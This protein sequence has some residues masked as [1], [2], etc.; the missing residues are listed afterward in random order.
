MPG[1]IDSL[2]FVHQAIL[3]EADDLEAQVN[4]A[5]EPAEIGQLADRIEFFGQLVD[6]HTRGEEVGLFPPLVARD[7]A[8]AETYL[9][10]HG[11][12]RA[13]FAELVDLARSCGSGDTAALDRI[14]RQIVA[15]VTHA[16]SHVGKENDLILPRVAALFSP[17][18]QGKM[19]GDI[20]SVFTPEQTA[21]GVPWIVARLDA[22]TAAIYVD[23]LSRAMPPS[24]FEAARG[25]IRNGISDD[26]WAALA[27][28]APVVAGPS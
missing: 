25:W 15:L 24:V 7:E 6:G 11:E 23:S 28:R 18:E 2:R 5:T 1:P 20:L 21:S 3:S 16:H 12:E 17:E 4:A 14:R 8:I 9:V 19:V 26:Q 13:L 27:E 10:D 22:D